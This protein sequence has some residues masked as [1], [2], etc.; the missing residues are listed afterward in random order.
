MSYNMET[1]SR[2]ELVELIKNGYDN[3][4]RVAKDGTIFISET[5]GGEDISDLRFRFETCDAG[6]GYVGTEAA[7]DDDYIN[8]IYAGLVNAWKTNRSGYIDDWR[9]Y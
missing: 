1:L 8:A 2:E 6:N 3:Q 4:I 9:M 7:A 5:V